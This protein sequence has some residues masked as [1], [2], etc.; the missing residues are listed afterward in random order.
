[1]PSEAWS[2][3]VRPRTPSSKT[4]RT[5]SSAPA[6]AVGE[7]DPEQRVRGGGLDDAQ[8]LAVPA[9]AFVA[10]PGDHGGD[11]GGA[12]EQ[13]GLRVGAGPVAHQPGHGVDG[14]DLAQGGEHLFGG[15]QHRPF[16]G[17]GPGDPQRDLGG[18]QGGVR[19]GGV[20]VALPGVVVPADVDA[21]AEEV[22]LTGL[23]EGPAVEGELLAGDPDRAVGADDQLQP[24]LPLVRADGAA[25]DDG[26]A[27]VRDAAVEAAA[28]GRAEGAAAAGQAV[29]GVADLLAE[30]EPGEDGE[31]VEGV[32]LA[33]AAWARTAR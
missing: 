2:A 27:A 1:M 5:R 23:D 8:Q 12:A 22:L 25:Q 16:A 30:G 11:V 32:G 21:A 17:R 31:G 13:A 26:V 9:G 15:G 3:P 29:E 28:D 14:E 7:V 18:D 20:D 19:E 24:D 6:A 33:D 10:E 4:A